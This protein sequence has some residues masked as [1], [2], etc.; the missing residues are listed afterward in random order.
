MIVSQLMDLCHFN[1]LSN[2]LKAS[3]YLSQLM[4]IIVFH[5]HISDRGKLSGVISNKRADTAS[6]NVAR[7]SIARL[8]LSFLPLG[9]VSFIGSVP[10]NLA[11]SLSAFWLTT[12]A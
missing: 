2:V 6:V 8:P 5:G 1:Q 11:S 10:E 3:M 4:L 7:A 12:M 9:P